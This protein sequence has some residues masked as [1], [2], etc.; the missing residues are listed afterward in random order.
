MIARV[1]LSLVLLSLLSVSAG[2][3]SQNK[4]LAQL[5]AL[6]ADPLQVGAPVDRVLIF[7]SDDCPIANR[8][9]PVITRLRRRY[10]PRGIAFCLVHCDPSETAA[11]I[12]AH[13]RDY[14]LD[15]PT[16]RDPQQKL[17]RPAEARVVPSAAVFDADG[18]LLYHGRIDDRFADIG[19]ERPA[20]AH[21]DLE[22]A[23]ESILAHRPIKVKATQ[24]IGCYLPPAK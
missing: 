2:C 19:R 7:V 9:A 22:E 10:A 3:I 6:P 4:T 18:S 13:D 14:H 20:P 17:A 16:V 1:H 8:Y 11:D 23:L 21:R 12:R 24:A 5:Q 15:L